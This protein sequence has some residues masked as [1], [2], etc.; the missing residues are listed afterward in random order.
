MAHAFRYL[1]VLLALAVG[2]LAQEPLVRFTVFSARPVAGLTFA[3]RPG[4]AAQK[5][6]FYPT[7][8]SPR[9]EFHGPMPV[10][11][12]DAMGKVLAEATIPP[13]IADALLL[14]SAIEVPAPALRYQVAVLD[15][16][17]RG[18][19]AGELAIV[20][21]SGLELSGNVG[22]HAVI[23]KPGLNPALPIGRSAKIN[24]R[25]TLKGRTYSSYTESV[26]LGAKQRAL[27]VLFPPYYRGSVEAQSRVLIDEPPSVARKI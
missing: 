11:F 24:L 27:L 26:E 6:V 3:P 15:D 19:N 9:Y 16:G 23:L 1:S 2:A 17:A 14:F 7:A 5:V 13:G 25:A 4:A 20:N 22:P 21:L 12:V 8:R 10:Q 18:H